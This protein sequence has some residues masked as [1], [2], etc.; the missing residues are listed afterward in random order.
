M[1]SIGIGADEHQRALPS[2]LRVEV[3]DDV[4]K[5]AGIDVAVHQILG[6]G[7]EGP[8]DEQRLADNVTPVAAVPADIF[9]AR[10]THRGQWRGRAVSLAHRLHGGG[11]M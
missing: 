5:M 8:E 4:P 6:L 1:K 10:Q 3:G 7:F 9:P 11:S 2:R